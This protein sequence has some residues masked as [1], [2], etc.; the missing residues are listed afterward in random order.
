MGL[1]ELDG[2]RRRADGLGQAGEQGGEEGLHA[3]L[4]GQL[5]DR[6]VDPLQTRHPTVDQLLGSAH[7]V[8][9]GQQAGDELLVEPSQ[10]GQ[11]HRF[12]LAPQE[13]GD[14]AGEAIDV[15]RFL[16][17]AVAAGE[18]GSLAL[19]RPDRIGR[20]GHDGRR[21]QLREGLQNGGHGAALDIGQAD[22]QENQRGVGAQRGFDATEPVGGVD[23]VTGL[24]EQAPDEEA[25]L[26]VIVDVDDRTTAPFPYDAPQATWCTCRER[27]PE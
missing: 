10:I 1:T 22:I 11:R 20:Q 6:L 13:L 2:Q 9:L 17:V 24:L 19:P 12:T 27:H 14:L 21:R 16:D 8:E 25:A 15:D 23:H 4:D 5:V 7:L 18:Q 26:S 3:E